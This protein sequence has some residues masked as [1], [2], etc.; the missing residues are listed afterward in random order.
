MAAKRSGISVAAWCIAAISALVAATIIGALALMI[1]RAT[2]AEGADPSGRTQP[3]EV[4]GGM[5][6]IPGVDWDH[7][8]SINA[9][10]IG[11]IRVDG[12]SIDFPIVKAPDEEPDYYLKHDIY[13]GYNPMGA[14]YLDCDSEGLLS[15]GN[16]VI[17]GHHY[18]DL[19]FAEMALYSDRSWASDHRTIW[20]LTPEG[21]VRSLEVQAADVVHGTDPIKRTAFSGAADL[22]DYWRERFS[23]S[24]MKLVTEAAETNQ[25]YMFVTCSYNFWNNE[26]TVIYAVD[27][28][29]QAA[30]TLS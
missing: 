25:L 2:G 16:A 14:I 17:Y 5:A 24:D 9:D 13:G 18:G 10:I 23:S 20:L 28:D 26:R 3:I 7:W 6:A 19:M 12:T 27:P 29:A 15:G 22:M 4:E 30:L 8:R 11:W 21:D 1:W